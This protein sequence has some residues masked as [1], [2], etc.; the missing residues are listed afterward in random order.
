MTKQITHKHLTLFAEEMIHSGEHTMKKF[1]EQFA[2][3]PAYAFEWS[4]NG[5]F[6]A[7][8]KLHVGKT[9]QAWL[10]NTKDSV[11]DTDKEEAATSI[12]NE[13]NRMVV[14]AARW[15]ERSTSVQS[16]VMKQEIASVWAELVAKQQGW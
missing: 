13:V 15:P 6:A 1:N 16:N 10:T 5:A 8:A 14:R 9:L 3:D 4:G 12:M 7:A 11:V 2:K